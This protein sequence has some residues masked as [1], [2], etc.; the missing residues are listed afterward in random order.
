[1]VYGTRQHVLLNEAKIIIAKALIFFIPFL[2][3]SKN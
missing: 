1:L 2:L 3:F